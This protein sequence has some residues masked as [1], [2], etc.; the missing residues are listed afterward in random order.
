MLHHFYEPF[1]LVEHFL[2]VDAV[3]VVAAAP[4]SARS[5]FARNAP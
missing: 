2:H 5:S 3:E 1:P 4:S